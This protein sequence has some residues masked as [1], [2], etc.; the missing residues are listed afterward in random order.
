[1]EFPLGDQ[2]NITIGTVET[3]AQILQVT[4]VSSVSWREGL[5]LLRF[6]KSVR[7]LKTLDIG[8]GASDVTAR[9]L[10]M[11]ADAYAIDPRV[12]N[13]SEIRTKALDQVAHMRAHGG[14]T[15]KHEQEALYT[16][17][18]SVKKYP[19]RYRPSYASSLPFHDNFF[20]VVFSLNAVTG[21]LDC[22]INLL[23]R[24]TREC[25]RVTK[26]GRTVQYAPFAADKDL[27]TGPQVFAYR[28]AAHQKFIKWLE[29]GNVS[30][31]QIEG[32][33]RR[34]YPRLVMVK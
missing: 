2:V 31:Y 1:M 24:V 7:G 8:C 13:L 4:P 19:K 16:F 30:D 33:P 17:L 6:P 29:N 26:P 34:E 9:L 23:L 15:W 10:A 5:Q 14:D 12:R 21:Y 27:G 32:T 11:G 18:R 22:D 20:D 25:L 28:R 3:E